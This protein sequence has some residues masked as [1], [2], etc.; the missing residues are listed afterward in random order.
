MDQAT[1]A[2]FMLIL[3]AAAV[4]FY[5]RHSLQPRIFRFFPYFLLIQFGYQFFSVAYSFI[6]TSHGTNHI[7]FNIFM[8][9]NIVYFS[10]FF[11]GIIHST[12]KRL[13]I[14]STTAINV[15]FY[16]A[17]LFY[18]QGGHYIMT[19]SRTLMGVLIVLYCLMYFHQLVASDDTHMGNPTRNATF[20]VVTALFFFYLCST[21]TLSLWNYLSLGSDWHIGPIMMR[22]FAFLLYGM[23]FAGFL[24][25]RPAKISRDNH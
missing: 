14:V 9:F 18:L 3:A 21:L 17:N 2:I 4:G 13:V 11:H 23:Y 5:R 6:I 19:Y 7:I 25:H 8:L 24:L 12:R 1:L 15:L 22:F 10:M 16:L 20:W